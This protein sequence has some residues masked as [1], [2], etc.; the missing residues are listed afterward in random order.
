MDEMDEMDGN[1]IIGSAIQSCCFM[2]LA[3]MF[4]IYNDSLRDF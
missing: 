1:I 2:P 3:L 4:F